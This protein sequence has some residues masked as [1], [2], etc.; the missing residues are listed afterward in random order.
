[1]MK[2][3]LTPA[4]IG[5]QLAN[6]KQL[7]FEVT[8][9]CNLQCKYCTYGEMYD[10]Y[11]KRENQNMGFDTAVKIIDYLVA[12]WNSNQNTSSK[13]NVY[14]SFYGGEP[15]LNMPFIKEVVEYVNNLECPHRSF[16]FSMTTNAIL[17]DRYMDYLAKHDFNLLISLDG[18]EHNT[19]YRVNKSNQPVFNQI[20]KNVDLLKEHFP[21]Y[22]EKKV[23]FNAVLHN[24]SSVAEIY[25]FFKT[26]YNK[27]PGIGEVNTVGIREDK[28]DLFNTRYRNSQESLHQAENYEAIEQDMFIKSGTYQSVTTYLHQHSGFVYRDY[29]HLLF[30]NPR[31]TIPTGTC[32]PF[33]RRM[34]ITVNGKIMP[35]ERIGQQF[36]LGKVSE[37]GVELDLEAIAAKYNAY[38]AKIDQLCSNCYS[39][40]SCIQ[41]IF[42]LPNPGSDC[43]VCYGY[44]NKQN[45]EKYKAIQ[46]DFL[47]KH[48]E[49]YYRIMEEV[50]VE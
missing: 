31:K 1:M 34:F 7:T 46:M 14:I 5:Y 23:F 10:D 28:K 43:P 13:R 44:T 26:K 18:N 48:P 33:G 25:H 19:S 41:C 16:T 2:E 39:A 30:G 50:I 3:Y 11:D 42:N 36:P 8:D 38:Y 21:D 17:L 4:H 6:L 37:K 49:E 47:R 12:L 24:R 29:A 35:C 32:I 45:F 15:L 22:F 27:I 9:A 40:N 20:C